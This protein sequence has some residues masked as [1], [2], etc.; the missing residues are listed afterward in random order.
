MS[1]WFITGAGRGMGLR[2]AKA[3]LAVGHQVVG[4]GRN[5]AKLAEAFTP[6]DD[7]L[8]IKQDVTNGDDGVAAAEAAIAHFGPIVVLVNNA[9]SYF[10]GFFEVLSRRQINLQLA[11]SLTGPMNVTRAI[12]PAMRQQRSGKIISI[13]SAAGM[14]GMEFCTAYSAAKFGLDGWSEALHAEGA[15]LASRP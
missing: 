6:S 7:M 11:T 2:I 14:V 13:S 15:P 3:A 4:T 10:G 8:V 1:V 5:T 12:L 9:A